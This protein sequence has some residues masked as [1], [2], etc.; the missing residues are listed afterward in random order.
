M[1]QD[2][3]RPLSG[4]ELSGIARLVQVTNQYGARMDELFPRGPP[5]LPLLPP[6]LPPPLPEGEQAAQAGS[7]NAQV[8][9]HDEAQETSSVA[10]RPATAPLPRPGPRDPRLQPKASSTEASAG[11]DRKVP[12]SQALPAS[13]SEADQ[14][15]GTVEDTDQID[16]A[17]RPQADDLS[18]IH[19]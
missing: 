2:P 11:S 4:Q 12:S 18:L 16:S 1:E 17:H 3:T 10:D 14:V 5:P 19:I 8:Q 6:P 13:S 9:S 7:T 15:Q